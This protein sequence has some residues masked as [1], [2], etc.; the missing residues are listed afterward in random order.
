MR[1]ITCEVSRHSP[2]SQYPDQTTDHLESNFKTKIKKQRGIG[3]VNEAMTTDDWLYRSLTLQSFEESD[4][5]ISDG[6]LVA[7]GG[8]NQTQR[9]IVNTLEHELPQS[10]GGQYDGQTCMTDAMREAAL[11][12]Q[13]GTRL[14]SN[15]IG[16]WTEAGYQ[17]TPCSDNI[18]EHMRPQTP[19]DVNQNEY[20]NKQGDGVL[21]AAYLT[22][23][24]PIG[25]IPLLSAFCNETSSQ[26]TESG[27]D[28]CNHEPIIGVH[29]SAKINRQA[30]V[31]LS[32]V[33]HNQN[34][35]KTNNQAN[36]PAAMKK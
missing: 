21:C 7:N 8:E 22:E 3:Q 23:N 18:A 1:N 32:P 35:N 2:P 25:P 19:T 27:R 36:S 13:F 24:E 5:S 31:G 10:V 15:S 11:I 20:V 16:S 12:P 4:R 28:P 6:S 33:V 34:Y 14:N 9:K 29:D 30:T 26:E 17:S